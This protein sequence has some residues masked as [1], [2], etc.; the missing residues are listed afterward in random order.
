MRY[1]AENPELLD[2]LSADYHEILR[3]HFASLLA[4]AREAYIEQNGVMIDFMDRP[5]SGRAGGGY[6]Q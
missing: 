2:D 1:F 5:R 4:Q 3:D 6:D